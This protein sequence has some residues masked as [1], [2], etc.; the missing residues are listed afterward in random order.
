MFILIVFVLYMITGAFYLKSIS[1]VP[2]FRL[3]VFRLLQA[4]N[5]GPEEQDHPL[6]PDKAARI[7]QA[8]VCDQTSECL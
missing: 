6:N 1:Y 5:L 7:K 3:Q 8:S 4:D 2:R